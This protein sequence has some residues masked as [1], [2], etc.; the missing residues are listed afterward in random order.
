MLNAVYPVV[1]FIFLL[2]TGVTQ[3]LTCFGRSEVRVLR[4]GVASSEVGVVSEGRLFII[5][6]S[7]MFY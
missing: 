5:T 1:F 4:V 2:G 3:K 7:Y 6:H